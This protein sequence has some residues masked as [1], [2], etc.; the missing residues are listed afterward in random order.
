MSLNL[1]LP[2][3]SL[4]LSPQCTRDGKNFV[5][6]LQR[7]NRV[8]DL[9]LGFDTVQGEFHSH[10]LQFGLMTDVTVAQST[11]SKAVSLG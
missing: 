3:S 1:P 2:P 9:V 4:S 11:R 8:D 7:N 5:L 6:F 10:D